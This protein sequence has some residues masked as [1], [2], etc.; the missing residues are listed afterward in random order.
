MRLPWGSGELVGQW[1]VSVARESRSE[2]L[3]IAAVVG[4]VPCSRSG[5]GCR[6]APQWRQHFLNFL[7]LPHGQGSFRPTPLNGSTNDWGAS[8]KGRRTS[9]GLVAHR[10]SSC[11]A[12]SEKAY[13][14]ESSPIASSSGPIW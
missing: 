8:A 7:P 12:A 10:S 1:S 9:L 11:L 14:P 6:R 4:R 3:L 13:Q 2:R 5:R